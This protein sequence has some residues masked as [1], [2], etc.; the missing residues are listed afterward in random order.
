M[1]KSVFFPLVASL[2]IGFA[3]CNDTKVNEQNEALKAELAQTLATRDSMFALIN[4]IS[5]GMTQIKE[6]EN[7]IAAPSALQ[8]DTQSRKDQIR[9]DMI[10]IQNALQARRDRLEELEKK[11]SSDNGEMGRTIKNLKAQIAE[12]QTEIATLTNKLASANIQIEELTST[13]SNLTN[14]VDTLNSSVVAERQERESAEKQAE[15]LANELNTCYY[16]IGTKGELKNARI[17]ETGFLRKTK[18]LKSDYEQSY[19]TTADK[20]TLSEINLHSGKAK[21]LTN[22]PSTSYSIVDVNG[23]KVLR[24]TD[25]ASFWNLSNYLVIQVD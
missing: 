17:I 18:I 9:N 11:L 19:F 13:V 14:A 2:M 7:I 8:G 4:D 1:R 20:R 10:A 12:Q 3:S 23:Q 22:Q 15:E 25:P 5:D 16:A 24:I 21:V 6:L